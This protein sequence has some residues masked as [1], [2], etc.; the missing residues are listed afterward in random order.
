MYKISNYNY[1]FDFAEENQYLIYNSISNGLAQVDKD[2]LYLLKKGEEGLKILLNDES[3]KEILDQFYRGNILV[4]KNFDELEFLKAKMNMGKFS[5]KTLNL[6]IVT[7]LSCNL[8]CQ[9]CYQGRINSISSPILIKDDILKFV[10]D[11]ISLMGYRYLNVTWYGGE[12]LME[13]GF[14]FS[15]AKDLQKLCKSLHCHYSSTIVT[16]GTILDKKIIDKLKAAKVKNIQITLDGPKSIHDKRRP[17]KNSSKSS[18]E[19]IISNIE[20]VFGIIP[21]SLRINVDKTNF[22]NTREL[23]DEFKERG[24]FDKPGMFFVYIGFTREWTNKCKNI[25]P[26]CFSMKEFS[27]AEMEFQA[28]LLNDGYDTGSLYPYPSAMCAAVSPHSFVIEPDGNLHKCWSDVGDVNAYIGNIK[29]PIELNPKLLQ[30][31]N[32]NPIDKNPGCGECKFLPICWG[33][34]PYVYLKKQDNLGKDAT[35]NCSPWK[36]LIEQKMRFYLKERIK[37]S[38][39]EEKRDDLVN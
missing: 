6:T 26:Y 30:W 25:A 3:K 4:D 20:R 5:Q 23:L 32:Y 9:Y 22:Q 16:N 8:E 33:G 39:M 13:K 10:E 29:E 37:K 14:I 1:F 34:C 15:L 36:I 38:K 21:I 12:P 24:W 31:L 27:E 28:M 7:T 18:F 35:Y 17:F 2:I 19:K 11:R